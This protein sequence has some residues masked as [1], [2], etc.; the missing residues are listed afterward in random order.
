[1]IIFLGITLLYYENY[2]KVTEPPSEEWSREL[3]LGLTPSTNDP[4]VKETE[5]GID[6]AYLTNHGVHKISYNENLTRE[7]E[8]SFSIPYNKWTKFYI[9][10]EH[11]IYSDYYAMYNGKTN[12]KIADINQFIPL[13]DSIIFQEN[14]DVNLYDPAT[15]ESAHLLTLENEQ[16]KLHT[17]ETQ[18]NTYLLTEYNGN[19]N[20]E[21]TFYDIS[22]NEIDKIGSSE[23]TAKNSEVVNDL[24]FTIQD[25]N[26]ALL[27]TTYQKRNMSGSPTNYY[28]YSNQPL[29]ENP[30]FNELDF[31]DPHGSKNLSEISDIRLNF[32][33][34]TMKMLFKGY[35]ETDTQYKSGRQFNIYEAELIETSP[36]NVTRL[37]NTPES[38]AYPQWVNDNAIAWLDIKGDENQLLFASTDETIIG[39]A[40]EVSGHY[41]MDALGK[42]LG[43][44]SYSFLTLIVALVWFIWPM[45]FMLFIMFGRSS[46]LDQD[47]GW[48]FFS[49]AS[50][51]LLAAFFFKDRVF[52]PDLM[53][54]APEYLSFLASP[55][56]YILL[57]ALLAYIILAV[58]KKSI[59]WSVSVKL[60]YF[61]G[62]HLLFIT[63]FF[64]PYLL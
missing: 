21:L 8:S 24:Q 7:K 16:M 23:F 2:Q 61:I 37:S 4:V 9:D 15:S 14:L 22:S 52:T 27:L 47:R 13:E 55:F 34:N 17:F 10:R 62:V 29:N 51:Y 19:G 26:Y 54:R 32:S 20:T 60:S 49:G 6:A 1:M 45:V 59:D 38:S 40:S 36:V 11:L 63:V 44:L 53:A 25:G 33:N 28:Y 56:I 3:E 57:F 18:E 43:M 31:N 39:K 35:G 42:T 64:G 50:I 12:D 41:F 30:E 5:S 48:V 58:N 46:A